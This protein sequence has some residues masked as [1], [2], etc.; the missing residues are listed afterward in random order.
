LYYYN[1]RKPK[2]CVFYKTDSS[3]NVDYIGYDN[4]SWIKLT[5]AAYIL[6]NG[7][8]YEE[9]YGKSSGQMYLTHSGTSIYPEDAPEKTTKTPASYGLPAPPTG[10]YIYYVPD[11]AKESKIC[12]CYGSDIGRPVGYIGYHASS[13]SWKSLSR[14]IGTE[15]GVPTETFVW[16]DSGATYCG[17]SAPDLFQPVSSATN[18]A[19]GAR[20]TM[21]SESETTVP[22]TEETTVPTTDETTGSSSEETVNPETE[23]TTTSE[24]QTEEAAKPS[25]EE[26]EKPETKE[27]TTVSKEET[28]QSE[29]ETSK[30]SVEETTVPP[31]EA[32]TKP[33]KVETLKPVTEETKP[34]V[35]ETMPRS[36]EPEPGQVTEPTD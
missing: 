34:S 23:E 9:F 4:D 12:V 22:S 2:Q 31:T 35:K 16:S 17:H 32:T 7:A 18:S 30:P 11:D 5:R 1:S 13:N 3:G 24:E 26:T 19:H 33:V 20:M 27:A 6:S 14:K 21:P 10:Y 8:Q 25:A 29:T 28:T 15:D 36:T